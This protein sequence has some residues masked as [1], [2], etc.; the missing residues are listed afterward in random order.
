MTSEQ[1]TETAAPA[2]AA[3]KPLDKKLVIGIGAVAAVA[4]TVTVVIA[5]IAVAIAVAVAKLFKVLIVLLLLKIFNNSKS[6]SGNSEY[7]AGCDSNDL[8]VIY[9]GLFLAEPIKHNIYLRE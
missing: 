3:K 8:T 5:A 2:A 9:L 6:Y 1:P 4:V 7:Y